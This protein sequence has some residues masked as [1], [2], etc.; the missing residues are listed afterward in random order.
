MGYIT[1]HSPGYCTLQKYLPSSLTSQGNRSSQ[2]LLGIM[3]KADSNVKAGLESELG[4]VLTF[5]DSAR[6]ARPTAPI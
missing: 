2:D 5:L 6:I 1:N 4:S 3:L